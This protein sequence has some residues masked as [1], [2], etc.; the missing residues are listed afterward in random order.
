MATD[1]LPPTPRIAREA[2]GLL[3]DA[4]AE[5]PDPRPAPAPERLPSGRHRI[6]DSEVREHQHARL[7]EAITLLSAE[8]GYANVVIADIVTR[9]GVSKSTFYRF[10][11][12]KEECLFDAHKHHCAALIAAIDRSCGAAPPHDA[13]LLRVGVRS[14]F[15]YLTAQ[16]GAAHLLSVGILSSGPCGAH[17]YLV[18]IEALSARIGG[19]GS[20]RPPDSTLAAALFTAS[21]L[22][23]TL[24]AHQD[25]DLQV[26][27]EELVEQL[28]A[29]AE[30]VREENQTIVG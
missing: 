1:H 28:L 5:V 11:R 30:R 16:P 24:A 4:T 14:A 23:H 7:I 2:A 12:T 25:M 6:S 17:R 8:R 29:T 20:L 15:S 22:T 26:L 27:E 10:Y 3:T 18:M 21:A 9:A 13:G 19:F